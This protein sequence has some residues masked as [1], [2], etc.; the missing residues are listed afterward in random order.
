MRN[1][2]DGIVALLADAGFADAR[3]VAHVDHRFGR[4]TFVQATHP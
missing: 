1:L 4:I 2:G 3:E